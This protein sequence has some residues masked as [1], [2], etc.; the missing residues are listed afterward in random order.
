[1]IRQ[2]LL[3]LAFAMLF[4]AGCGSHED[5]YFSQGYTHELVEGYWYEYPLPEL[6]LELEATLPGTI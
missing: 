1:M 2:A 5:E 6:Y 3:A 4:A